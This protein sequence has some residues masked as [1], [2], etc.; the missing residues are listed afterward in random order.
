MRRPFT[1]RAESERI[2]QMCP[3]SGSDKC[4]IKF[5]W[6]KLSFDRSQ[7]QPSSLSNINSKGIHTFLESADKTIAP[8]INNIIN[9][10]YLLYACTVI[11]ISVTMAAAVLGIM[12]V[13]HSVIISPVAALSCAILM[14]LITLYLMRKVRKLYADGRASLSA[15]IASTLS[16]SQYQWKLGAIDFEWLEL[17]ILPEKMIKNDESID[18]CESQSPVLK[19]DTTDTK[20]IANASSFDQLSSSPSKVLNL[21][22][23]ETPLPLRTQGSPLRPVKRKVS[24]QE[25]LLQDQRKRRT[26]PRPSIATS[27]DEKPL[28][29]RE[30]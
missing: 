13:P 17:E 28:P 9:L 19:H 3:A 18:A 15:L 24:E 6:K 20:I 26:L 16:D 23:N 11:S 29:Q 8:F 7:C 22:G 30:S 25:F 21:K 14:P 2:L 12:R 4:I 1:F 5:D 27:T 10:R